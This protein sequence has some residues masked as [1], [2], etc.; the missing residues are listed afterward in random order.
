[1]H[2]K[3]DREHADRG[4]VGA[5]VERR[6]VLG[7]CS[8]SL[9]M[10]SIGSRPRPLNPWPLSCPGLASPPPFRL[11]SEMASPDETRRDQIRKDEDKLSL[12][13]LLS[14]LLLP[15]HCITSPFVNRGLHCR[16]QRQRGHVRKA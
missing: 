13:L 15:L 12:S 10:S 3:R 11:T 8:L 4:V 9:L 7:L 6:I 5:E 14:C 16:Y 1:M 2:S